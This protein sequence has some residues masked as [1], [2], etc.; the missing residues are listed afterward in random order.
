MG[1][2]VARIFVWVCTFFLKKLTT[3][4]KIKQIKRSDM[5]TFSFSVYTITEEGNRQGEASQG[6]RS[7]SFDPAR[8]GVAPSL[9]ESPA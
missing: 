3:F 5:V 1:I 2:G 9:D 7:G 6:G 8:P 4:F